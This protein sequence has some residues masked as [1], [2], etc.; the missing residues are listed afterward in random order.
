MPATTAELVDLLRLTQDPDSVFIGRHP[1]TL[2]QRTYGGQVLA[3]S[4]MAAYRT[5]AESRVAHSLNSYFIRPGQ[6][7]GDIE[8]VVEPLRDGRT[9]SMRRVTALQDGR[10]IFTGSYSFHEMEE[11][12]DHS[13]PIAAQV[14]PP[15]DCP[16][17]LDISEERYG[18]S[19]LW[20]EWDA[21]DVRFAGDSSKG[22]IIEPANHPAHMRVWVRTTEALP[23]GENAIHQAVLAYLSDLTLLSV[24]VIPHSVTYMSPH[25]QVAT[26]DH[27]MHF[28]RAVRADEWLLYDMLSPSASNSLGIA[29]GRLFQDGKLVASCSQEGLIRVLGTERDI[30]T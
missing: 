23:S 25:L 27:I 11:G 15:E 1:R 7:A 13:D 9:F 20:H 6:A 12:L 2:M 19:P 24:T 3:Q 4:L 30:L 16:G 26:L 14:P 22:G 28:H 8:Y 18:A 29:T 17:F 10:T 5:V 21:L